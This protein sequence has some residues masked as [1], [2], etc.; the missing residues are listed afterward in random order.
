MNILLLCTHLNPGGISRYVITLAGQLKEMGNNVWIGSSGGSWLVELKKKD[1]KHKFIPI[2]TKSIISPKIIFSFFLL[3][4]FLYKNKIQIVHS[5]TRV[6]QF[7]GYLIYKF[8]KIPYISAFHGFYR[9][10]FFRKHFKFSGVKTI[11]VSKAVKDH[12]IKDLNIEEDKIVLI[13]NGI[14]IERFLPKKKDTYFYGFN[15]NDILLGMLGR[16]SQEKGHFLAAKALKE[17]LAEYPNVYLL[18][19][20]WGKLVGDLVD[21]LDRLG[22]RERVRFFYAEAEEFLDILDILLIPSKKEGFG[23]AI[24]EAFA[25]SI[26]VIGFNVGGIAEIIRHKQNGILFYEYNHKSLLDAIKLLLK[27]PSLKNKIIKNAKD[28]LSYFSSKR[29][30]E[31]TQKIYLEL[32]R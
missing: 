12:L 27:E 17:L 16:I 19:C 8:L 4:P 1:I 21:F 32:I 10:T 5:N 6:T 11:A 18:I 25:K 13:Y 22:I 2:N 3:L 29:M 20:G 28:N 14:D 7:L 9:K 24:I 31:E 15:Q 30:A 23:Y 26:P